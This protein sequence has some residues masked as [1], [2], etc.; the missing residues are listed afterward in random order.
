M[1]AWSF[2]RVWS[3]ASTRPI[4]P[5]A[6]R[7]LSIRRGRPGTNL[8][9][10]PAASN[11]R[12]RRC[13][14]T[15]R[16]RAAPAEGRESKA[17]ASAARPARRK[18]PMYTASSWT[19]PLGSP[20]LRLTKSP[21]MSSC[22]WWRV[23]P[24]VAPPAPRPSAKSIRRSRSWSSSGGLQSVPRRLNSGAPGLVPARWRTRTA[25][26]RSPALQFRGREHHELARPP[27]PSGQRAPVARGLVDARRARRPDGRRGLLRVQRHDGGR[28]Q[29]AV[30]LAQASLVPTNR[31]VRPG[32]R[33]DDRRV[34]R[35]LPAPGPVVAG[36]LRGDYP[37]AYHGAGFR[38]GRGKVRR[39][40]LDRSEVFPISALRV[41]QA[42]LH[43]GDG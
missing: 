10:A 28:I 5:Q 3:N 40:P 33:R 1:E 39:A 24:S 8:A 27:T 31:L 19:G 11:S 36:G 22:S 16:S 18:S 26:D 35:R 20:R 9:S 42:G 32:P 37:D 30:G 29:H 21:A 17:S 38:R 34:Q 7:R 15:S 6:S 41:R 12:G 23:A 14:R 13:S 2:G 25:P 43:P 4:R